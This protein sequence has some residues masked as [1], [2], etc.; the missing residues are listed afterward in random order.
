MGPILVAGQ[1]SISESVRKATN[2]E[3]K[4]MRA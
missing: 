2:P 1:V 4:S 3:E